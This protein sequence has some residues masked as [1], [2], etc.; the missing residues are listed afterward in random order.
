MGRDYTRANSRFSL[1]VATRIVAVNKFVKVLV[2][3]VDIWNK[4]SLKPASDAPH[5]SMV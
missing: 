5:A 3:S 2:M 1:G 4:V